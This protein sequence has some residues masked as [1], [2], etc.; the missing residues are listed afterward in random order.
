VR[1]EIDVGVR[2]FGAAGDGDENRAAT[3]GCPARGAV[4]HAV[5]DHP[6]CAE[7]DT[8]RIGGV[9]EHAG[10][11]FAPGVLARELR[12]GAL[13]VVGAEAE[14]IEDAAEDVVD[15]RVDGVDGAGG[16]AAPGDAALI[17]DD[18]ERETGVFEAAAGV[19]GAG[20]RLDEVGIAK[21]AVGRD[22]IA[23]NER[24]VAIEEDGGGGHG[25]M[26][27]GLVCARFAV[28]ASTIRSMAGP[29]Q[30]VGVYEIERELGRGGMGVVYLGRDTRLDRQVAIKA[31]PEHLAQDPDR[32]ARFEREART[33]A[34]LN[35]PNVAGIL[36]LEEHDGAQFLVLEYVEGVALNERL[37]A[38]PLP[39][40]EAIE[41]AAQV[42]A[43]IDAAHEA[44]VI[45]RDLKPANVIVTPEGQ[46]K[47]LDFGLARAEERSTTGSSASETEGVTL[48]SPIAHS[49]TMPG[50]ILGTAAYMSPEQARGRRVDKRTDVWSF[51]VLLYEM[52]TGA[53]PFVGETAGDS[54][55][56]IL[57]KDVD[58]ARLPASTPARVRRVLDRCL[59][60]DKAQRARDIGDLRLELLRDEEAS[61]AHGGPA[62]GVPAAAV[63][64]LLV[65]A[66]I[67]AAGAAWLV[68]P[69]PPAMQVP[70]V[71][72]EIMLPE[73]TMLAHG[74]R[75]GLAISPDGRMLVFAA[76]APEDYSEANRVY[77]TGQLMLRRLDVPDAVPLNL[78]IESARQP[79]FSPDGQ[80]IAFTDELRVIHRSPVSGG[81]ATRVLES[82]GV[83]GG[84]AW[85]DDD[86]IVFGTNFGLRSVASTGGQARELTT[87]STGAGEHAHVFPHV[88][89]RGAG[90]LYTVMPASD[91]ERLLSVWVLPP[92]GEPRK[93]ID[94]ASH[95]QFAQGHVVFARMGELMAAPFDLESLSVTGGVRPVGIDVVHAVRTMNL[96]ARNG[97]AQFALAPTG[98]LV[99][100][101]G[102]YWPGL[103]R[104]VQWVDREGSAASVP[105][106]PR[107]YSTA[108][109]APDGTRL[110]LS[111]FYSGDV[112]SYSPRRGV[113]R[114]VHRG[115]SVLWSM[116]GPEP[117][118]VT[119]NEAQG[120]GG[121]VIRW[122]TLGD[123][124]VQGQVE[125]PEGV[126]S[127]IAGEWTPDGRHLVGVLFGLDFDADIGIW[128]EEE[129]WRRLPETPGVRES[130]PA[131]SPDGRWMAYTSF[132]S[133]RR[134]VYVRP[135][136]R[137]GEVMQVSGEGGVSPLWSR[138]GSELFYRSPELDG[139]RRRDWITVVPVIEVD[140]RLDLGS[141]ERL[142]E[143][144]AWG[145]TAPIRS[146]DV[147]DDGRFLMVREA[148]SDEV[149]EVIEG[150]CP[151]RLRFVQ[152]WAS[153]L[154]GE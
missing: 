89:P 121:Y 34:Q 153:R 144:T 13:G 145:D 23:S 92:D 85:S 107:E 146:W 68:K 139:E 122:L 72:A 35:H 69:A 102:S 105:L 138:D 131:V 140:G 11:G 76:G 134:E 117:G 78:P 81:I 98:D 2:R 123:S 86:Q 142:F 118:Q 148:S 151:D 54:I 116:W 100:A 41:I 112:W 46:A 106:E 53:S 22:V 99:Y 96:S 4:A 51:G 30:R 71:E 104:E 32:L 38:G 133:G 62:R 110:L 56:A 84:L 149:Q 29:G 75:P 124:T 18:D 91:Q 7:V 152:N 63:L 73:G 28:A 42:A 111:S 147:T 16:V 125:P 66:A 74:C 83:I 10:R 3:A 20:K 48:T 95:A 137:S 129:G 5:A 67:A 40:D 109:V 59:V 61:A 150:F 154:D 70:V 55:G 135:F 79:V 44:G 113:L 103:T 39:V 114:S 43:G 127:A 82:D 33:L 12:D 58:H 87:T 143:S 130:W 36:G 21:V 57:H 27:A 37:D 31:L 119:F 90:L 52:L 49:P 93:V 136:L 94:Q 101:K 6:R 9:E 8:E 26:V 1:D 15:T 19:D 45:H 141:A 65:L 50:V 115:D 24:V 80:S 126:S 97:S 25:A 14:G 88:L 77:F 108:R 64:G 47:V 132:E 17:R 128:S 60:R 120:D